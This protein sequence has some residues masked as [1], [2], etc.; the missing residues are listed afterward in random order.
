M[1]E[2]KV[3]RMVLMFVDHDGLGPDGVAEMLE[4]ARY[5]NHV[6]GPSVMS[7]ET[8]EV[9]W[10]DGHALNQLDQQADAFEKLFEEPE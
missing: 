2:T 3:Y 8:R 9:E 6:I 4:N 7:V 10:H 1:K 5:P